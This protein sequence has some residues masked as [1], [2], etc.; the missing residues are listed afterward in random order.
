MLEM[1]GKLEKEGNV[2][3]K[4]VECPVFITKWNLHSIGND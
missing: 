4:K 1:M 2:L 3:Q